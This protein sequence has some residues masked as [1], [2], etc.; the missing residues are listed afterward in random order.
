[1]PDQGEEEKGSPSS[2]QIEIQEFL[3]LLQGDSLHDPET[4]V[5]RCDQRQS[6][7][8][9]RRIRRIEIEKGWL[10]PTGIFI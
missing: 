5:T 10:N 6:R 2:R 8:E 3:K 1:M 7:E 4:T 9:R